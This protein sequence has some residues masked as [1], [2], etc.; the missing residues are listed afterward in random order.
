[1]ENYHFFPWQT[2]HSSGEQRASE[3]LCFFPLKFRIFCQDFRSGCPC[4]HERRAGQSLNHAGARFCPGTASP[5]AC[6]GVPSAGFCGGRA[7][8]GWGRGTRWPQGELGVRPRCPCALSTAVPRA[9]LWG[10]DGDGCVLLS[11]ALQIGVMLPGL[12]SRLR[13]ASG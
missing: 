9:G 8:P 13:A 5:G 4:V 1:M 3:C 6:L 10:C 2:K 7:G 11:P 12:H